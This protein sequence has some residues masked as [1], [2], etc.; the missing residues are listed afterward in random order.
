MSSGIPSKRHPFPFSSSPIASTGI[1]I[2]FLLIMLHCLQNLFPDANRRVRP[3]ILS[4][5][6]FGSNPLF[7]LTRAA[8]VILVSSV[9]PPFGTSKMPPLR[10]SL[11]G[12]ISRIQRSPNSAGAPSASPTANPIIPFLKMRFL[13]NIFPS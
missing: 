11:T 8:T 1:Q 3:G 13:S 7:R 2:L 12:S 9:Q 5:I 4:I 10:I 6:S